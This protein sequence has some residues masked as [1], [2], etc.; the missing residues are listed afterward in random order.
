MTYQDALKFFAE[1]TGI[2]PDTKALDAV[3][4]EPGELHSAVEA[5]VRNGQ[6]RE[7]ANAARRAIVDYWGKEHPVG[8]VS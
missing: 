7:T 1:H 3:R 6:S 4:P 2:C 8:Q 5:A